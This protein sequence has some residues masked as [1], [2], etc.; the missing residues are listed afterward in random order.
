M[1][2]NVGIAVDP[3]G[4]PREPVIGP[5]KEMARDVVVQARG[6]RG[7]ARTGVYVQTNSN[8]DY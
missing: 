7:E 6:F 8:E 2:D 5:L 3:Q 4:C 1:I